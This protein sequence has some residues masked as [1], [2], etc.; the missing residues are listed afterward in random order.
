MDRVCILKSGQI[1]KTGTRELLESIE[2]NG[3]EGIL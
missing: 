3:F 2:K 1:V